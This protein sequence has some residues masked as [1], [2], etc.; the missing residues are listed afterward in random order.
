MGAVTRLD[1]GTTQNLAGQPGANPGELTS[2][3]AHPGI[4]RDTTSPGRSH[5]HHYQEEVGLWMHHTPL[6]AFRGHQSIL[7]G[8]RINSCSII[9]RIVLATAFSWKSHGPHSMD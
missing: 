5:N 6:S 2:S 3:E 1:P 9:G 4:T 7:N 8:T